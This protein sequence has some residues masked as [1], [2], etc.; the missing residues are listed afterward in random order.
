MSTPKKNILAISGST[1]KNS[2]N[3]GDHVTDAPTSPAIGQLMDELK[4]TLS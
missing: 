4:R 2:T 3:N 1:R